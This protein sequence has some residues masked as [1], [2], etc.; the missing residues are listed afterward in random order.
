M[1]LGDGQ[2]CTRQNL[3]TVPDKDDETGGMHIL[4]QILQGADTSNHSPAWP[5]FAFCVFKQIGILVI[6]WFFYGSIK[7]GL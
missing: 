5:R 1:Q 2:Y 7:H 6:I 4:E 3:I